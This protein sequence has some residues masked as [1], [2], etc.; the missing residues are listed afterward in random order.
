MVEIQHH[1]GITCLPIGDPLKP[2]SAFSRAFGDP[3]QPYAQQ[4][5]H[6]RPTTPVL[7]NPNTRCRRGHPRVAVNKQNFQT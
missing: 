3:R 2:L 6:S 4:L 1:R 5:R 7:P